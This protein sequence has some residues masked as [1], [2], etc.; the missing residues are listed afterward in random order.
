MKQK[1]YQHIKKAER[2]EIAILL[3]KNHNIREIAGVLKRSPNTISREIRIN[4]VKGKY[5]PHKADH[6][7]YVKRKYSKYQGMKVAEDNQLWNYVEEK[8]KQD[9]SPE[10]IAGRLKEIDRH[11][12]YASRGAIYKFVY[13]VY[14]RLLEQHLRY[15]GRRRKRGKRQKVTQLKNRVFIDERPKI[16]GKKQ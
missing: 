13:S 14:G 9:W 11:I 12:K 6:K 8:L 10:E 5:D 15:K 4:S 7:A 16:V 1:K 2:F 3:K